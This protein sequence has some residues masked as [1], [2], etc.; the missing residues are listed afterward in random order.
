VT[1]SRNVCGPPHFLAPELFREDDSAMDYSFPVDVY[2]YAVLMYLVL[3]G[4]PYI[5]PAVKAHAIG[6]RVVRGYRPEV[7]ETV[8]EN[9][10]L[11]MHE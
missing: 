1:C 10:R 9:W 3:V 7:P 2:A 11:L 8:N 5:P 6:G 4:R